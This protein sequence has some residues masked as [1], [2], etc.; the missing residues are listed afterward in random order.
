MTA[1]TSPHD[2]DATATAAELLG[3]AVQDRQSQED[4]GQRPEV[5]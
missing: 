5:R 3:R 4:Y 1:T 2:G